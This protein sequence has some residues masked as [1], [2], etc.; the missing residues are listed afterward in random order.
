MGIPIKSFGVNCAFQIHIFIFNAVQ[1]Y[2][3]LH[4]VVLWFDV[5]KGGSI[6]HIEGLY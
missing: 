2:L 6:L 5:R 1:T 4:H 3:N